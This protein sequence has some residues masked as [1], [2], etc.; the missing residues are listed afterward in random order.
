MNI[1]RLLSYSLLVLAILISSLEVRLTAQE[2][3]ENDRPLTVEEVVKLFH[4]GLPEEVIVAKIKKNG[5]AFDLNEDEL[6]ELKKEGV[7]DTIVKFLLDPS[8][9]YVPPAP[10]KAGSDPSR[11]YPSDALASK[12]PPE[13]G[14]YYFSKDLPV[15]IEMKIL[16][17]QKIGG[18]KGSMIAYLI[19]S[20]ARQNPKQG[21]FYMRLPEGKSIEEVVLVALTKRSDRRELDLGHESKV[22]IK[23]EAVRPFETLEVGPHLFRITTASLP[24]GEYLFFLIGSGEPAQGNFGRGYDFGIQ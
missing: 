7:T 5:K 11:H 9:P 24:L 20:V 8:L 4:A 3:S 6:L 13:P 1:K 16:L 2:A 22:E 14:L 17:G 18:K 23:P 21:V 10:S 12:V 19:G 15:A